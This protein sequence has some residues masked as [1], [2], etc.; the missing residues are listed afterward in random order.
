M[1]LQRL[2][3]SGFKTFL[4]TTTLSLISTEGHKHKKDIT[5]VIGPN[6][7][8]KSNIVDA[9]RWVLGEQSSKL[10]RVRKPEDVI[11]SGSDKLARLSLANVSLYLNNE[12]HRSDIDYSE[13]I[14]TRKFYRDG[15]GEYF[16]NNNKVRLQDVVLLLAKAGIG[17]KTFSV[18]GQGMI[19]LILTIT[20]Y[21]RKDFIDEAS[22]IRHL[23]I[24][25]DA[26]QRKLEAAKQ[27]LKE[28][29]LLITELEPKVRLLARQIKKMDKKQEIEEQLTQNQKKYYGYNLNHIQE[30]L[31]TYNTKLIEAEQTQRAQDSIVKDLKNKLSVLETESHSSKIFTQLQTDYQHLMQ[32]KKQIEIKLATLA[33]E[34]KASPQTILSVSEIIEFL[35]KINS[36]Q[37]EF[38]EH[39]QKITTIE[40][41]SEALNTHSI[42]AKD[43]TKLINILKGKGETNNHSASNNKNPEELNAVND[44]LKN[45]DD[46]ITINLQSMSKFN[47]NEE[48]T[49]RS[50]FELQ[51]HLQKEQEKSREI[52]LALNSI[53]VELAKLETTKDN[54]WMEI[55]NSG[56]KHET[57]N[58]ALILAKNENLSIDSEQCRININKLQ[59]EL[60]SIG[61]IDTD[62]VKEYQE[63]N[64]R[65]TFLTTQVT[66]LNKTITDLISI[67]NTLE[68]TMQETFHK[69]FNEINAHFDKYFKILFQGGSA[70]LVQVSRENP[71][72]PEFITDNET[73]NNESI[74][75]TDIFSSNS[76]CLGYSTLGVEMQANPPGKRVKNIHSLS[77][78]ERTLTA[79]ALLSALIAYNSSPFVVLDEVDAALDESNSERFSHIIDEL[80]NKTQFIIVTHNRS[81]MLRADMIYG[82]TMSNEGIS[83]VLSLKF[84]NVDE[85][86]KS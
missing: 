76:Q 6:G 4:K 84:N 83:K 1:H 40:K 15:Q 38:S 39:L 17:Q 77:G 37:I 24:K 54:L 66:D 30:K 69:A 19:D 34:K 41:I 65:Y 72:N 22:G 79:L 27:H 45:I 50:F 63:T 86:V 31:Q 14:I 78:G 33:N 46:Q 58:E 26:S 53:Q 61:S 81:V 59:H 48:N 49:K 2:E 8:G 43:T 85:Y 29:D 5:A 62:I 3:I 74:M 64:E 21:E 56:I 51:R 73:S 82:V 7:S 44:L 47:L 67:S 20:P 71:D 9:I 11:F 32:S 13:I 12:D 25:K 70:K 55:N 68:K 60:S 75:D 10:V 80:S 57:I 23:K 42:I 35:E 16:I 28:A 18:V 36:R 52:T